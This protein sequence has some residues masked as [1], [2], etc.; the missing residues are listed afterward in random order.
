MLGTFL[1]HRGYHTQIAA[2]DENG[3]TLFRES[4]P[5]VVLLNWRTPGIDGEKMLMA[6]RHDAPHIPVI[7][8]VNAAADAISA[9]K[10][11]AWDY[12]ILPIEEM[13]FLEAAIHRSLE[14]SALIRQQS[15]FHNEREQ[16]LREKFE[17]LALADAANRDI[18]QFASLLSH[19]LKAP[20]RGIS[21]LVSW[22]THD[23]AKLFDEQGREMANL[24][25]GQ[26]KRMERLLNGMLQYFRVGQR[27]GQETILD[28]NILLRETIAMLAPP[29]HIHIRMKETLPSIYADEV[30]VEQIFQH[31]IE[32]AIKFLDKSEGNIVIGCEDVG[33]VWR[34]SVQDNGPGIDAKYHERIFRVCEIVSSADQRESPGIGLAVVKKIVESSGG[35]VWLESAVGAGSTFFFTWPKTPE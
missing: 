1:A 21:Q 9:L 31:L 20:L 35:S 12:L 16:L 26:V 25:I 6:M 23:Y 18:A 14:Y 30:R 7:M 29:P 32:N 24:L 28:M 19:D 27:A 10:A 8:L 33:D 34:F 4:P 2:G 15:A 22:L 13:A 11:G 3:L 17:A 5:D